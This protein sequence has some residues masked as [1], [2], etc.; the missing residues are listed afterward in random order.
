MRFT[1]LASRISDRV[2]I[3]IPFR[4]GTWGTTPNQRRG[5]DS[6]TDAANQRAADARKAQE[7][8]NS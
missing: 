5:I 2:T 3:V 8:K 6:R 4:R 7:R 1:A